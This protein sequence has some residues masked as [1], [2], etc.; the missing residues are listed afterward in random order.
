MNKDKCPICYSEL[1]VIV[2]SP[3]YDCGHLPVEIEHFESGKHNYNIYTVYKG[4]KLQLCNFCDVDFGSY[5]SDYLGLD[6]NQRISF[7]EFELLK[8]VD[9]PS[10]EKDK[11]CPECERRLKFLTFLNDL[12]ELVESAK[13]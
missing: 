11:Y 5:K 10:L 9:N 3:C 4:L 7:E 13:M 2:C 6:N 8:S 12:R 1:E